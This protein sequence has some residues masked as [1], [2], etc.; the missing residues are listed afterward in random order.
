MAKSTKYKISFFS[1][2]VDLANDGYLSSACSTFTNIVLVTVLGMII[3]V[4]AIEAFPC[5]SHQTKKLRRWIL[6]FSDAKNFAFFFEN[7]CPYFWLAQIE[8]W[9]AIVFT[10]ESDSLSNFRSRFIIW[11]CE[12]LSGNTVFRS[13]KIVKNTKNTVFLR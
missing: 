3:R 2:L 4:D 12:I 7:F 11:N 1:T 6:F 9:D 8:I 10:M 13:L 5:Y